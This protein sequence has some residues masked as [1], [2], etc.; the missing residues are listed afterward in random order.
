M[1][2]KHLKIT[3]LTCHLF[4]KCHKKEDNPYT[5]IYLCQYAICNIHSLRLGNRPWQREKGWHSQGVSGHAL[6]WSFLFKFHSENEVLL[7]S[8]V[9]KIASSYNSPCFSS[10]SDLEVSMENIC[11]NEITWNLSF[12]FHFN[13][14][15]CVLGIKTPFPRKSISWHSYI[16]LKY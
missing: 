10:L 6:S 12:F 5:H 16:L 7:Q 4:K 14:S 8:L 11:W 1:D 15:F 9:Y 13:N 3:H 2:L